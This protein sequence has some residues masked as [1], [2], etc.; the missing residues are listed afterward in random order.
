MKQFNQ[1]GLEMS[2]KPFKDTSDE[3]IKARLQ[4]V[5]NQ[6]SGLLRHAKTIAVLLWIGDGS[7]LLEYQGDMQQEIEWG[8]YIGSANP[9]SRK[10]EST[11]P[12]DPDEIHHKNR[13]YCDNPP[14][15]TYDD[16]RRIVGLIKQVGSSITNKPIV[17]GETF[18][19]GPEFAVSKFKYEKHREICLSTM[20][21]FPFVGCYARLNADTT[22]YAGFP[23]GIPQDTPFGTFFGR[24]AQ[25]FLTDLGFD[26]IWFSNGF[27][28]G[29]EPWNATGAVFDGQS[30]DNSQA[31]H[32]AD[33]CLEFWN[34]FR[35]ECAFPIKTRGTNM[36]T[37]IDISTDAVP[38]RDIYR[39][40]NNVE[41]PPNSPWVSLDGDFGLELAGWM[42]HIAQIPG[43]DFPFRFYT[44]DPWW[45]NSP[46][47]DR[48][49]RYPH[50]I[51]MPMAVS[52][53]NSTGEVE[54]PTLLELL[55]IDNSFG[56]TPDQVP[57]EVIPHI[58]YAREHLPDTPGPVVWVYPFDMYHDMLHLDN[59]ALQKIFLGDWYIRGAINRGLPLNT[60]IDAKILANLFE[61]NAM[62]KFAES[63][64]L[65]PSLAY[66]TSFFTQLLDHVDSGHQIVLY[67]SLDRCPDFF[68]EA[69]NI[70]RIEP[71]E[72]MFTVETSLLKDEYT[73]HEYP[74]TLYHPA[75]FSDGGIDT[76]SSQH[77]DVVVVRQAEQE[78]VYATVVEYGDGK[79]GWIRGTNSFT[80]PITTQLPVEKDPNT[81]VR[82]SILLRYLLQK[83]GYALLFDSDKLED[84]EPVQVISRHKQAF[85]FSGFVPNTTATLRFLLPWGAPLMTSSDTV[86][87]NGYSCY[88][89]DHAYFREC[90]I[91]V[92]NQTNGSIIR[93][94]ELSTINPT[95]SRRILIRG[96]QDATVV[97]FE[98]PTFEGKTI[99][100]KDYDKSHYRRE[101][102]FIPE[103]VLNPHRKQNALGSTCLLEHCCGNLL[104]SW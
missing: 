96:L 61:N 74:H 25:N 84:D 7:E 16:I 98:E 48:Y 82:P 78:R 100:Q 88:R 37:G 3:Y 63:I 21:E 66:E 40:I 87:H 8:R 54:H 101:F 89:F 58:L 72:G 26:Y 76:I 24:Q 59:A 4:A 80:S 1:I 46:W 2:L 39:E 79:I 43:T 68:L 17:V 50:D 65:I 20:A 12:W 27:G 69:L 30:F 102:D 49:E 62:E 14:S 13:L 36:A 75:A 83:M 15:F 70:S 35:S 67:G 103:T 33:L 11:G 6:W 60:V 47:L 29:I 99:F 28:F 19:P 73:E 57:N 38:I 52:R 44:H 22:S 94:T 97:F 56:E 92:K 55:T 45:D 42:S 51:Y 9:R 34:Q 31:N 64:L 10:S 104:I 81:V 86:I 93:T 71:L 85:W 90:R 32:V 41:P 95:F 53:I 23:D 91:F 5:F 18:D 77:T